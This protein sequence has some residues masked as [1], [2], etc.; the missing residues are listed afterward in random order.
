[1]QFVLDVMRLQ[2]SQSEERE[3]LDA[4]ELCPLPDSPQMGLNRVGYVHPLSGNNMQANMLFKMIE[5]D[6]GASLPLKL[7]EPALVQAYIE[8]PSDI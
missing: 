1:M 6:S 4:M 3:F 8:V 7:T 5:L 2:Q